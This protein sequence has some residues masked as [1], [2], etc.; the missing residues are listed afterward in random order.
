KGR[1]TRAAGDARSAPPG[2]VT[3]S[4]RNSIALFGDGLIDQIPDAA[5]ARVAQQQ[6]AESPQVAGQIARLAD[7]RIGRFGWHAQ[8][9][10]LA[11]FT[12]TACAVKLGLNVPEHPQSGNPLKPKKQ[13]SGLDLNAEQ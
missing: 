9:A 1:V 8:H 12:L 3:L 7:G 13:P 6:R 4:E 10:S 11:D 2:R 5:I